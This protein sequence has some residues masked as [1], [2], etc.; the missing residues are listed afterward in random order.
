MR[1]SDGWRTIRRADRNL[2]SL[3]SIQSQMREALESR[4]L[5]VLRR[6]IV[7]LLALGLLGALA[8]AAMAFHLSAGTDCCNTTTASCDGPGAAC[9]VQVCQ[10]PSPLARETAQSPAFTAA[11]SEP[12]WR[13]RFLPPPASWT[14]PPAAFPIAGPPA[15]LRFHRFLL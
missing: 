8:P 9:S 6:A 10:Q 12:G 4:M 14:A 1:A 5:G 13:E 11:I 2:R 15:Y 7:V 3:G